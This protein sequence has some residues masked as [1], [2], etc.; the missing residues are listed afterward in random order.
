MTGRVNALRFMSLQAR[1]THRPAAPPLVTRLRKTEKSYSEQ[2]NDETELND[3][4]DAITEQLVDDPNDMTQTEI[5]DWFTGEEEEQLYQIMT[6]DEIVADIRRGHTCHTA[7][8]SDYGH[9]DG[10]LYDS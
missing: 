7:F 10:R 3:L 6:D 9:T 8:R 1:M 5:N 4:R 2:Q